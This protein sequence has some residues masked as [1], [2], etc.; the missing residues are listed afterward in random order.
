MTGP[1]QYFSNLSDAMDSINSVKDKVL[2]HLD[3]YAKASRNLVSLC[4]IVVNVFVR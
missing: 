4:S 2:D 1:L 3:R